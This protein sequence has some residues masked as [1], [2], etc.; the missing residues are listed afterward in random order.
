MNNLHNKNV[1]DVEI[2]PLSGGATEI[3]KTSV[4]TLHRRVVLCLATSGA[5][6]DADPIT[7]IAFG[8][9]GTYANG[10]P[11]MPN[12]N[13]TDVTNRIAIYPVTSI[14]YPL[15]PGPRTTAQYM[16]VIP[17]MDLVSARINEA[18]LIGISG[19]A[20]A[21]VT[22]YDKGK[23]PGVSMRFTFNDIF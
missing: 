23:D 15:D 19:N 20:H 22:F 9:S 7:H 14:T 6:V 18:A 12:E 21:V 10:D 2:S 5:R 3:F 1:V 16:V 8:N 4:I 11:I 13:Q 17:P